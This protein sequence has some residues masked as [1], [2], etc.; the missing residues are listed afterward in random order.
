MWLWLVSLAF[1]GD[2]VIT[3][4]NVVIIKLDGTPLE[5]DPGALSVTVRGISGYHPVEITNMS[6]KRLAQTNLSVA[7]TGATVFAW[8]GK[9]IALANPPPARPP[10]DEPPGVMRPPPIKPPP[11]QDP[12]PTEPPGVMKPPPIKP[13][14]PPEP[15]DGNSFASLVAAVGKASFS[16]DKVG[17]VKQAA[18][19][20]WFTIDQVG[21]LVDAVSFSADKL[22]VVR[23]CRPKVV[24]PSNSF[25]LGAHFPFS[26]DRD[27]AMAMFK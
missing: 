5:Y 19:S 10:R 4:S 13:P 11:A 18:S 15:M 25:Q 26:S 17:V 2:L 1:G 24:D 12:P 9:E 16:D 23:A 3:T 14:P 21:R 8:D 6:G 22:A 20:N 27:A 7:P